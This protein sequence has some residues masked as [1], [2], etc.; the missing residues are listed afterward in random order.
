MQV[1]KRMSELIAL[2]YEPQYELDARGRSRLQ[3]KRGSCTRRREHAPNRRN[4]ELLSTT[5]SNT[6]FSSHRLIH[7]VSNNQHKFRQI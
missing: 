1:R 6:D 4:H 3:K 5:I 2:L 7:C